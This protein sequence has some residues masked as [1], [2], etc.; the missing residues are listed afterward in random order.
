MAP[1]RVRIRWGVTGQEDAPEAEA[2][3]KYVNL[4]KSFNVE[5]KEKLENCSWLCARENFP[6]GPL[7]PD[8]FE[9]RSGTL[10]NT[11]PPAWEPELTVT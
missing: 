3:Q 6:G 8:E 10:S 9:E 7:A 2:T 11:W 4:C 1:E 5:D